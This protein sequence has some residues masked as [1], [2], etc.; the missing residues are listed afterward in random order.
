MAPKG[1][2]YAKPKCEV[3]ASQICKVFKYH[4]TELPSGLTLKSDEDFTV[5]EKHM[6]FFVE[7]WKTD[8]YV[9]EN[10]MSAGLHKAFPAATQASTK[11]AAKAIRQ[12]LSLIHSKK[13]SMTS[14]A[15]LPVLKKF[16]QEVQEDDHTLPIS[17][18]RKQPSTS[19]KQPAKASSVAELYGFKP[20]PAEVPVSQ[21]TISDDAD[22]VDEPS[23]DGQQGPADF[24][25]SVMLVEGCRGYYF[26]YNAMCLVKLLATDAEDGFA[27]TESAKM[28]EGLN[29]FAIATFSDGQERETTVSNL[30]MNFCKE[31]KLPEVRKRPAAV[32]RKRPA[33]QLIGSDSEPEEVQPAKAQPAKAQP[34]KAQ[35]AKAEPGSKNIFELPS[36]HKLKL[37]LFRD[38]AYITS[39]APGEEKY[40]LL[41]NVGIDQAARNGKGHHDIMRL[42]WEHVKTLPTLPAKA[43][44]KTLV[45]SLLA[46]D[47][48]FS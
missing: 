1:L 15:K 37:G 6:D 30:E 47:S 34:A 9:S 11:A 35:P 23:H 14:G 39:L 17:K 16:L 22:P 27:L 36:K 8:P 7:L 38:K 46:K 44:L 21:V 40:T 4:F 32:V 19:S 26:D 33:S 48:P 3:T 12:Q 24:P 25:E 5:L 31:A 29:G 10:V 18:P 41:I 20:N 43:D 2:P 42:V 13:R 45:L 28:R